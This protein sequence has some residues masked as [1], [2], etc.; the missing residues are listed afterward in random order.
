VCRQ[1][2]DVLRRIELDDVGANDRVTNV[3]NEAEDIAD[4]Q[5]ARFA[6]RDARRVRWINAV[7]IYREVN[8][9]AD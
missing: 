6:M 3:L 7:Y 5:S 9:A 8:R 4:R 2:A 1:S